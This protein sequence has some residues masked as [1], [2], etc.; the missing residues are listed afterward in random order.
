MIKGIITE[1]GTSFAE[2]G[3]PA[4]TVSGYDA[5]YPLRHRQEH[6]VNGTI[7]KPSDAVR[8]VAGAQ[9]PVDRCRGP[10]THVEKSDRPEQGIGPRLHRSDGEARQGRFS[11]SATASSTSD[12]PQLP[13]TPSPSS[14]GAR[15]CRAFRRPPTSPSRS[16]RSRS[17][18][19][20]RPRASPSSARPAAATRRA[21]KAAPKA[22]PS[23]SARR[24]PARPSLRSAPRCIRQAE[25][26]ERAK[27]ILEERAQDF[28][29][30]D[31]ECIGLPDLLPD[32]N[33]GDQRRRPGVQQDLLRHRDHPQP[34]R[35]GLSHAASRWR[36]R[37]YELVRPGPRVAAGRGDG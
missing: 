14:P 12:P 34:R 32:T 2:S 33:V 25:A 19:G 7:K 3:T 28:V 35:Q 13:P 24:S 20:R 18:A 29:T 17:M 26:D 31:G 1:I 36:S 37:R 4:L 10:R 6:A 16:P 9:L 23:G 30:G 21:S 22:A 15:D 8:A 5:L 27:A 11:T